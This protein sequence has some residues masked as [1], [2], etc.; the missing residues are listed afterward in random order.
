VIGTSARSTRYLQWPL[1]TARECGQYV[2]EQVQS[3]KIAIVFGRERTGLTNDELDYCQS[4]V[5]I[6]TNPDY[7]SLNVAAAVQLISYECSIHQAQTPLSTPQ[8]NENRQ[9]SPVNAAIMEGFYQHLEQ[10][11]GEIRYLDRDNPRY[12]MRRLRRLF[13]RLEIL[14]SEMN[15]LR[16]ILSA[17]QGRKFKQRDK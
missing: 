4:L 11:L 15:I 13:G 2:A 5:H 1:R 16:G 10:T 9:E 17:M 14:P 7:S 12:L 6:P 8:Q 3:K